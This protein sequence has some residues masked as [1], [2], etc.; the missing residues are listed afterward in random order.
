MTTICFGAYKVNFSMVSS[1]SVLIIAL[2]LFL[3]REGGWG[4]IMCDISRC[5]MNIVAVPVFF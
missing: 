1:L 4:F 5:F 2:I 3:H